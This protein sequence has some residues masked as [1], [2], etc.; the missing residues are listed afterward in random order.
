M[1]L[2]TRIILIHNI[3]IYTD[4]ISEHICLTDMYYIYRYSM[5]TYRTI[6]TVVCTELYIALLFYYVPVNILWPDTEF[7]KE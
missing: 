2:Y 6:H 5:F 3:H 1:C 7:K 4:G